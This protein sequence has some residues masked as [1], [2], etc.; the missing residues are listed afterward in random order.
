[1]NLRMTAYGW[2]AFGEDDE[3]F[4]WVNA[5]DDHCYDAPMSDWY[6]WAR[7]KGLYGHSWSREMRIVLGL[8]GLEFLE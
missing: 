2:A 7:I 6:Q 4:L 1:M 5:G 8:D 3:V